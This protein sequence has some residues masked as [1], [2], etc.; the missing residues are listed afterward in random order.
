[1]EVLSGLDAGDPVV[2]RGGFSLQPGDRV[3]IA[4]GEGRSDVPVEPLHPAAVVA[5]S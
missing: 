4:K 2:V 1:V 3:A 5:R